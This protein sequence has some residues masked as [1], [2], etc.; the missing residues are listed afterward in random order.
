MCFLNEINLLTHSLNEKI[1]TFQCL[2]PTLFKKH[3]FDFLENLCR[4]LV[5]E[6]LDLF[7]FQ[8]F[9]LLC[10]FDVTVFVRR[11]PFELRFIEHGYCSRAH[12]ET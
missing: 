11:T 9:T 2:K 8:Y 7:S 10:S 4:S 5:F 1:N 12:C 3:E 6:G